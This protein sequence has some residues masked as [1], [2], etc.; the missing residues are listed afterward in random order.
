[1]PLSSLIDRTLVMRA[2]TFTAALVMASLCMSAAD[3]Q[4]LSTAND[5][6][7]GT[8]GPDTILAMGGD[9]T[10]QGLGGGD[11]IRGNAGNDRLEGGPGED[12]LRGG[13]GNDVLLGGGSTDRIAGGGGNDR[14]FGGGGEDVLTGGK[15]NDILRGGEASDEMSGGPGNDVIFMGPGR[16]FMQ[17]GGGADRF[18]LEESAHSGPDFPAADLIMGFRPNQGDRIDLSAIDP[19]PGGSDDAF[20]ALVPGF[21]TSPTELGYLVNQGEVHLIWVN[22]QGQPLGWIRV[23]TASNSLAFGG[24]I[25]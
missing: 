9:D 23:E 21:P 16:D 8:P 24:I 14:L 12:W 17:G 22:M 20:T 18:V 15:G 10:I 7:V 19:V 6:F 11:D 4:T 13:Q 1:M 5:T 3:A 2:I 25:P